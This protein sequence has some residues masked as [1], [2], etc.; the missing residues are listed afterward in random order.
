MVTLGSMTR[1]TVGKGMFE[2][3]DGKTRVKHNLEDIR[4]L[5]VSIPEETGAS[6]Y[7]WIIILEEQEYV[8]PNDTQG[9]EDLLRE[10]RDDQM[11]DTHPVDRSDI[12]PGRWTIW[13][14]D[15]AG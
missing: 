7:R 6:R 3:D 11:F 4:E 10:F 15:G 9:L 12:R 2:L 5:A 13:E 8:V 14:K 1:V